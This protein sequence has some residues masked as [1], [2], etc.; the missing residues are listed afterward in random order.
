MLVLETL[1][2]EGCLFHPHMY[3]GT[4]IYGPLYKLCMQIQTV[5]KCHKDNRNHKTAPHISWLQL[6]RGI[7]LSTCN[8]LLTA[9]YPDHHDGGITAV[10]A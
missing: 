3:T 7:Q 4:I 2:Q 10:F 5:S 1:G 9:I 6:D 8:M